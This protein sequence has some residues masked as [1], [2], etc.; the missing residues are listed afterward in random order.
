MDF[1]FQ[2]LVYTL[3]GKYIIHIGNVDSFTENIE[4]LQ[5]GYS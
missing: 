5:T 2:A 1:R 3:D 4:R